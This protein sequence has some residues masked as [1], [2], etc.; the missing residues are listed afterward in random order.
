M[1]LP[2]VVIARIYDQPDARRHRVLVDRLWP[3][4]I[5]RAE[6]PIDEWLRDVAPSGQLRKWYG[7]DPD[8][9]AEFTERYRAELDEPERSAA[10]AELRARSQKR[11]LAL[12]TAAKAVDI[13]HAA[14]LADLLREQP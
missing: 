2:D 11:R 13:S 9:F 3:R 8:R 5:K 14:V 7:H 10:F 6:A 4:G 1:T 12:V